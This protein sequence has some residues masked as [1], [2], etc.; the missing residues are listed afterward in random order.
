MQQLYADRFSTPPQ[1]PDH[2]HS[3]G[4]GTW[5]GR[6]AFHPR[7]LSYPEKTIEDYGL[8][9]RSFIF[10]VQ[11]PY[12]A[13]RKLINLLETSHSFVA[14]DELNVAGN[15]EGPE[16]K[17]DLTLS[18]LF[19]ETGEDGEVAVPATPARPAFARQRPAHGDG[20]RFV[21][22][23]RAEDALDRSRLP[24]GFQ[25]AGTT[26]APSSGF[27]GSDEPAAAA[28]APGAEPGEEGGASRPRPHP[29]EPCGPAPETGWRC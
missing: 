5:R 6:R 28:K 9:K 29:R 14:I 27:G 20:R 16:L 21:N 2:H 4:Q 10:S 24:G 12:P 13:L 19:A 26:C 18:T 25:P 22:R 3:G 1:P 7:A 23:S 8:I 15:T 11:G 17:I